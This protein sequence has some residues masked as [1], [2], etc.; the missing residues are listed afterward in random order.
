MAGNNNESLTI[1]LPKELAAKLKKEAKELN[2]PISRLCNMMLST[3]KD[4]LLLE[5]QVL[6]KQTYELRKEISLL[7]K[8]AEDVNN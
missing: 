7:C 3:D 4:E 1:R 2:V 5:R 6:M 8:E